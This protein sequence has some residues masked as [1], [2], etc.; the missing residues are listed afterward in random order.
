MLE[1]FRSV[2]AGTPEYALWVPG[3]LEIFGKHTDY[4][5]G[6][7]LIAPVPRGFALVARPRSD[8]VVALHD[9]SRRE[10][11][12]VEAN[13][14]ADPPS[15][16][17]AT[18]G[19]PADQPTGRPADRPASAPAEG[20]G[21][22]SA[23]R[24]GGWRR[25]ALTVV[26]RLAKNFPGAALGADIAFGSD[27][28]PASG[29]SSSSALMV[30][31]AAALVRLARLEA[32]AEWQ[33]NIASA[34]DAAGYYACIENG[35]AFGSLEGDAGVGT[36]GGSEDHIAIVCG[37]ADYAAAWTFVPPVHVDRRPRAR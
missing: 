9:A 26:R 20:L 5:G 7:T 27:L 2:S 33:A 30:A 32:R 24:E 8:A 31:V 15:R 3:R 23:K 14:A 12:L 28:A 18:A 11:F 21:R 22:H 34:A 29:M 25:Y 4:G 37:K 1:T 36:H 10:H 17:R 19:K 16:F 6:H 13:G 35:M